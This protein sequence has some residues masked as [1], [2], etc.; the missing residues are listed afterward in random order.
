[1]EFR[2]YDH[3]ERLGHDEV[4]EITIGDVY[5]FPKIDGTNASVW[6]GGGLIHCGSRTRT[7]SRE[8]DNAGFWLWVSDHA[9]DIWRL[10]EQGHEHWTLYGE[11]LVPHTLKTYREDVWRRFWVF[12]VFDNEAGAYLHYKEWEP[13]VRAAGLDVIDPLCVITNP[14]EKQLQWE[15]EQNAYLILDGGGAGEGVVIKNYEWKNR[16]GRQPWAKIV[17]NEFKEE[18]RRAFGVNEKSGEFQVE[19]AIAEEFVTQALVEK[20]RAKIISDIWE[21]EEGTPITLQIRRQLEE[22]DRGKVIPQLLGTVFY[23]L[24]RE[25]LWTALKKHKFPVLDFKTL[26]AHSILWTKR[27]AADL[28]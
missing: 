7:L 14:S 3:V 20:T 11:W 15:V 8:A 4:S 27:Y 16:F 21:A 5:V 12:D 19:A 6:F 23:E 2:K 10:A 22:R 25:E 9:G 17:R 28:F 13:I 1:M 26:R 18:N 24:V